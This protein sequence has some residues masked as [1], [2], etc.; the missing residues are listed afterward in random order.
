MNFKEIIPAEDRL[1]NELSEMMHE[2]FNLAKKNMLSSDK[3]SDDKCLRCRVFPIC[4]GGCNK[5]RMDPSYN[6]NDICPIS[7]NEVI[8]F[9][10]HQ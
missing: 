4:S 7:E 9:F 1:S 6:T 10:K 2:L 8:N 5:Y 3:F